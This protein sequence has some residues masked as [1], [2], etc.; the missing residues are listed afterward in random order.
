MLAAAKAEA[1]IF[2][3]NDAS[4]NAIAFRIATEFSL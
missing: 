3:F 4:R 2:E 1:I